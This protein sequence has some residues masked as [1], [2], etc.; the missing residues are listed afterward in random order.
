MVFPNS[1]PAF[2]SLFAVILAEVFARG[3]PASLASGRRAA[4]VLAFDMG[5]M[6][7]F[8][9]NFGIFVLALAARLY[10]IGAKPFWMD[11][12]T[13]IRRGLLPPAAIVRDSVFFHQLPAFFVV[14][15][16]ALAFGQTEFWVRLP[17]ALFGAMSCVLAY[18]I[19]RMLA[20]RPDAGRPAGIL[21]GILMACAPA[22]VQYGQEARSYTM[23]ICAILIAFWGLAVLA[24]RPDN[25]W[26]WVAYVAGTVAAL[27]VLSDA[28]FWWLAAN[29]AAIAMAW[30]RAEF[31]WR[32]T[33]AQSVILLFCAP[34]FLAITLFG[35]RGALGGLDWVQ[36]TNLARLWWSFAQDYLFYPASLIDV[37]VFSPGIL[38]FGVAVAA[39]AAFGIYHVRRE[40]RLMAVLAAGVLVLPVA[41]LAISTA[42]PLLM[43]R[44]LLWSAAP[45]CICAGIAVDAL[46]PRWRWLAAGVLALLALANLAPYY[47]DE[48]K[49]RWDAAGMDLR[50]AWRP[51]DLL[52]VDD[53]Q[54]VQLMNIYLGRHNAALPRES[55][56]QDVTRA[57]AWRAAGGRVWAVQGRVGQVDHESQAGFLA[58]I[59]S[60]GAPDEAMQVGHDILLLRFG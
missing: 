33:A 40:P 57:A 17:A 31:W 7:D 24:R 35:Q 50:A 6:R 54:A 26:G 13:T 18:G 32:W 11:E 10:G 38:G 3:K 34:W 9:S 56:T 5:K 16:A 53:P 49:P 27:W 23:M 37:K 42:T 14:M 21:A 39:L 4:H 22:M 45:L 46:R 20:V 30:R 47:Q 2:P 36:P 41:L 51:G 1:M 15:H 43:P 48:T 8:A 44:Y 60:F 29:L 12:V 52:L 28:L 25:R 55:W 59:A 58:R 19:A